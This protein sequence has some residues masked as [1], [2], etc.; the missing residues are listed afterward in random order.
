M[1]FVSSTHLKYEKQWQD[2]LEEPFLGET[3]KGTISDER[4]AHWLKQ[5]YLFVR[6]A[7]PVLALMIP[8]APVSERKPLSDA[9]SGLQEEIALFESMAAEHGVGLEDVEPEPTNLGYINFMLVTGALE[10]FE[11]C[12]TALY[13]AEKAYLDSWMKV[14]R[15][16]KGESRWQRFID[17]WT[18]DGFQ[19][20]VSHLA[21]NLDRLAESTAPSLTGRMERKFLETLR[22]EK[23]FWKLAYSTGESW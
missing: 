22:Y 5:D 17:N 16:Q 14:K 18:S 19:Q 11:V 3:A 13:T 15:D 2:M 8:K 7:I 20:W 1:G 21:D 4:F 12:Y 6:E 10:P 9:I 23:L